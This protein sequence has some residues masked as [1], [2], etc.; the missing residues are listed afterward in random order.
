MDYRNLGPI[1]AVALLAA[2][3]MVTIPETTTVAIDIPVKDNPAPVY[4]V[5][6]V[7]NSHQLVPKLT[8]YTEQDRECLARNIYFEAKNQSLTGQMAVGIVTIKRVVDKRFPNT[9]CEVVKQT[10][11]KY[12]NGFPVRHKCQFSWYCDGKPDRPVERR[13]YKQAEQIANALLD[14]ESSIEDF[15]YGADHYHADYID[16]PAWTQSMTKVAQIDNHIFYST[17]L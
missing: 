11:H 12:A 13:S 3:K 9:L 2:I 10:R 1:A 15:T 14:Q 16:P 6:S 5:A 8:S 17:A 7:P 4:N